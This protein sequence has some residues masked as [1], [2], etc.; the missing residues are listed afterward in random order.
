LTAAGWTKIPWD[1]NPEMKLECWRKSFGGGH[2]SVGVGEFL[3]VVFSYG[4]NSAASY[5]STRWDYGRPRISEEDAMAVVDRGKGRCM[6]F[7]RPAEEREQRDKENA[8]YMDKCVKT[9]RASR[10]DLSNG[11]VQQG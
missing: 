9:I 6:L 4:A 7:I 8:E 10:K 3:S 11:T 5:C 2:V 1:G